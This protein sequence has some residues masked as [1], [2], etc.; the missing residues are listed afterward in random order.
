MEISDIRLPT[1]SKPLDRSSPNFEGMITLGSCSTMPRVIAIGCMVVL[2]HIR[3]VARQRDFLF[4]F[5]YI[6]IRFNDQATGRTT[7][8]ISTLNSSND[9][10][11]PTQVPFGGLI[12]QNSC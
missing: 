1:E 2:P 12:R 4:K 10:E 6:V 5:I 11:L 3:E 8:P 7:E 9:A